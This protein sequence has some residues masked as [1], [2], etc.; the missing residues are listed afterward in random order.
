MNLL[1][2]RSDKQRFTAFLVLS[3]L[4]E[5]ED[6]QTR[7]NQ[8]STDLEK[9]LPLES[10]VLLDGIAYL[11]K[12]IAELQKIPYNQRIYDRCIQ[13]LSNRVTPSAI[14]TAIIILSKMK[15]NENLSELANLLWPGITFRDQKIQEKAVKLYFHC[16]SH[17]SNPDELVKGIL[18]ISTF[19]VLV[20]DNKLEKHGTYLLFKSFIE[21]HFDIISVNF[22]ELFKAIAMNLQRT[23]DRNFLEL[24]VMLC[25]Q[26]I[27]KA[28]AEIDLVRSIFHSNDWDLNDSLT[29]DFLLRIAQTFPDEFGTACYQRAQTVCDDSYFK[30]ISVNYHITELDEEK[31]ISKFQMSKLTNS[32]IDAACSFYITFPQHSFRLLHII[33]E[34]ADTNLYTENFENVLIL[35]H[36]FVNMPLFPFSKYWKPIFESLKNHKLSVEVKKIEVLALLSIIKNEPKKEEQNKKLLELIYVV[37]GG[38]KAVYSTFLNN[39]GNDI[40]PYFMNE[41]LRIISLSITLH[42]KNMPNKDIIKLFIRLRKLS[43]LSTF[44]V[45]IFILN[46]LPNTYLQFISYSDKKRLVKLWNL[47][48]DGAGEL[49]HPYATDV[50]QFSLDLIGSK[51]PCPKNF[52]ERLNQRSI[53]KDT[54]KIHILSMQCV[55]KLMKLQYPYDPQKIVDAVIENLTIFFS[56]SVQ[57]AALNTLRSVFRNFGMKR[58]DLLSLHQKLFSFMKVSKSETILYSIL[59]ILGTIGPLDPLS[60][61]LSDIPMSVDF[62]LYD[63]MKR[64]QFY[65]DFVMKYLWKQLETAPENSVFLNAILF[66]F[67]FDAQKSS[68][69]LDELIPILEHLLKN[70]NPESVFHIIRSITLLVEIKIQPYSETIVSILKPYLA[71]SNFSLLALKALSALV[72][73]LR[74]S[75]QPIASAIFS[76]IL[77]LMS[78]KFDCDTN[79]YFLQILTHLVIFC[80]CS[81][82]LFFKQIKKFATSEDLICSN[83]LNFL[84]QVI[85]HTPYE[86]LYLPSIRLVMPL[87]NVKN[88]IQRSVHNLLTI[89]GQKCPMFI[90]KTVDISEMEIDSNCIEITSDPFPQGQ[91]PPPITP[92]SVSTVF[93]KNNNFLQFENNWDNWLLHISQNLVLCSNSPAIRACHPLLQMLT[94]FEHQLFPLILISV[95]EV[96]SDED[97]AILSDHISNISQN[98][99]TPIE[100][101]S[102]FCDAIDSMDRTGYTLFNSPETAGRIAVRCENFFRAVRFYE[103]T[104]SI[105]DSIKCEMIRIHARLQRRESALGIFTLTE[106]AQADTS[107][108]QDLLLWDKARMQYSPM[109]SESDFLGYIQCCSKLED[110]GEIMKYTSYFQTLST[111]CKNSAGIYFAAASTFYNMEN[112]DLFLPYMSRSTPRKCLWQAIVYIKLNKLKVARMYIERGMKLNASNRAPFVSGIYEPALPSIECAMFLEELKDVVD[113]RENPE[114][115]P[116]ILNI[117]N[118]KSDWIKTK[119]EHFR[120][121]FVI[122]SLLEESDNLKNGF[123]FL[124]AARKLKAWCIYDNS[125]ERFQSSSVNDES[126]NLLKAKVRFDRRQTKDLSEILNII[127][128]TKSDTIYAKAVCSYFSRL[129]NP[130]PE[131]LEMLEKVLSKNPSLIR[132][133]KHWTYANLCLTQV[134]EDKIYA[135]NAKKGFTKLISLKGPCFH[136]LCQLCS[137]CFS[138]EIDMTKDFEALTSASIEQIAQQLLAQFDHPNEAIRKSVIDVVSRFAEEHIQAIAFPLFYAENCEN[139]ASKNLANFL[140]EIKKKHA[141]F[142]NEIDIIL[143]GL[144][145]ITILDIEMIQYIIQGSLNEGVNDAINE[146]DK[147]KFYMNK[148]HKGPNRAIKTLSKWLVNIGKDVSNI[149]KSSTENESD[150]KALFTDL[151]RT[152][153]LIQLELEKLSSI[154]ISEVAPQILKQTPLTVAVPG[155]YKLDG[156]FPTIQSFDNVVKIIASQ[157]YPKKMKIT[158][159]DGKTYKYLLKGKEDLRLDQRVMQFFSLSNSLLRNDKSGIE[160]DLII[161]AYAIIPLSPL[162]GMISWAENSKTFYKLIT[163]YNRIKKQLLASENMLN[164][165]LVNSPIVED[166]SLPM[167]Q[168]YFKLNQ[169]QRVEAYRYNCQIYD[170]VALREAIWVKSSVAEM[171]FIQKTNFA[172]SN[173]LMSIVGYIVGLGDRHLSNIMFMN[174]N[175]HCVHIDFSECFEKA[176]KWKLYPEKVPFRLTRMMVRALGVSGVEG[177]FR[178][179]ARYVMNLMRRNKSSLLAFLDFFTKEADI[180]IDESD[181]KRVIDKLNGND[182]EDEKELSPDAQVDKLII[183]ATDE[184][185]LSQMYIGWTPYW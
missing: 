144:L 136:Y 175:G 73:V 176:N 7:L 132:A 80:G 181:Y 53:A 141:S 25:E 133:W 8:T 6:D 17:S 90:P 126:I 50:Y 153:T 47:I 111:E 131:V 118:T 52:S 48:L 43:P 59:S 101:L 184:Y 121:L 5:I 36:K 16:L 12:R 56:E 180:G 114:L 119:V 24:F 170:D 107:I 123:N 70:K 23:H 30:L 179:T 151:E 64:E 147:I 55:E 61:H 31:I 86:D 122:R 49:L 44:N 88:Q 116:T 11:F 173:A 108:L 58:V 94:S 164:E 130:T 67:Q 169:L 22:S 38:E 172:R 9:L 115:R 183:E 81:Q 102:I 76:N 37:Q 3:F 127:E 154:E 71:P 98:S 159:S 68:I 104:S 21:N 54:I 33:E 142:M 41:P 32:Y 166:F 26:Y 78:Y 168:D 82:L 18:S 13:F 140:E 161:E 62:H 128:T 79:L 160:K 29:C 77:D 75:F 112:I 103:R 135:M 150:M 14:Q 89:L 39:I 129:P 185:N 146:L 42:Q 177:D 10:T 87:I 28:K 162:A 178:L 92:M 51:I 167:K 84:S 109:K 171:W 110:W 156:E 91:K 74:S 155:F 143:N 106:K 19:N 163:F 46:V 99:N 4:I 69:Y 139:L 15:P 117:W 148:D 34:K 63:K 27:Q 97:R 138:N 137:L 145:D 157:K 120:I 65:L 83:A 149:R 165:E 45:F 152:Y 134:S 57:I 96:A 40:L 60:F 2:Q 85:Y 93:D 125:I 20:N 113:A 1:R 35:I 105:N 66:I 95:W 124:N 182:F 72:F 174:T 100:L 158:G